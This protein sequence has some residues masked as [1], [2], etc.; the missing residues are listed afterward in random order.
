MARRKQTHS[1]SRSEKNDEQ[2]A[3]EEE[4]EQNEGS[5]RG[6]T[7]PRS[8]TPEDVV[9]DSIPTP[10]SSPTKSNV[11]DSAPPPP[12]P[13]SQPSSTIAPPPPVSSTP[14]T[15]APLLQLHYYLLFFPK[16][17]SPLHLSSPL[18][19]I[20]QIPSDDDESVPTTKQQIDSVNEKLDALVESSKK[21]NDIVMK[22]FLDTAL[23]QYHESIDKCTAAVDDSSSLCKNPTA[24]VKNLIHDSKVFLD[25]LN[26]H[27]ETNATKVNASVASMSQSLQG[28]QAKFET[29]RSDVFTDNKTFLASVDSRLDKLNADFQVERKLRDD[30]AQHI[31][32]N[33]VQKAEIARAEREIS[34][35][36]TE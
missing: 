5:P 27:A 9:N 3:G 13:T 2:S 31:A 25:S 15:T 21:C 8:P 35:L 6:N 19:S 32:I 30:L 18:P 14:I 12:P 7:P 1:P 24:D 23:H 10:P 17:L 26:G 4:E 22:A 28:E 11:L 33:E 16:K 34:L 20:L 36:K 29:L